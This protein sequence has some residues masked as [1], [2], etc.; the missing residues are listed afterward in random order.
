MSTAPARRKLLKAVNDLVRT[1]VPSTIHYAAVLDA[2]EVVA[3][4]DF[5]TSIK[6]RLAPDFAQDQTA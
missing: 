4:Q 1:T 3:T 6:V 2:L 5:G